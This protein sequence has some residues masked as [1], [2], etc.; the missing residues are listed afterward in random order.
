[1]SYSL[2]FVVLLLALATVAGVASTI[3]LYG[4]DAAQARTTA[5]QISGGHVDAGKAAI[6]RYGCGACHQIPGIPGAEGQVG[7]SL[8][9]FGTRSEIAGVLV[10]NPQNLTRWVRRPQEIVPGNGMPDQGVT[11]RDARDIAA[12]LY[13]IRR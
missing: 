5:E 8:N 1:V 6:N 13:T 3:V 11:E 4:Q 10:N 12:Y 2:R 9:A 7:P